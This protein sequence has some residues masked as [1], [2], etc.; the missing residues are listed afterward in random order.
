MLGLMVVLD[1]PQL[2]LFLTLVGAIEVLLVVNSD[3]TMWVTSTLI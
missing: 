1:M 2:V 3:M